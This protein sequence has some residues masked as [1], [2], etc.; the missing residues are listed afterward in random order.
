M[1]EKTLEAKAL[2][3]LRAIAQKVEEGGDAGR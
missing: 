1:A 3:V 2:E